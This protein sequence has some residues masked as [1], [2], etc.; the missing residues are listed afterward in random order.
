MFSGTNPGCNRSFFFPWKEN[1]HLN[2]S[3]YTES[4]KKEPS[5]ILGV[6][7]CPTSRT[8]SPVNNSKLKENI[9]NMKTN[10]KRNL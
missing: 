1:I 7:L 9:L 3:N 8:I 5:H 2:T 4:H 10:N 6:V